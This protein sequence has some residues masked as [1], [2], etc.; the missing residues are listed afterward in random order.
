MKVDDGGT[1][2]DLREEKADYFVADTDTS[3][4]SSGGAALDGRLALTGILA[5]GGP[6]IE[7]TA[8]G[9]WRM[10][11]QPAGA[12]AQEQFSY[13]QRAVEGLC[14]RGESVSSLCR[15]GCEDPCG[16][17]PLENVAGA[18]CAIAVGVPRSGI[19]VF[20]LFLVASG[21]CR[22]VCRPKVR[23][24]ISNDVP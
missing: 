22:F 4:G 23:L 12:A 19:H 13:T 10:I 2:R 11:R 20:W 16:A 9:C 5:R 21:L 17:A 8:D 3:F 18:G 6:D 15:A 24:R 1:V 14:A 7:M